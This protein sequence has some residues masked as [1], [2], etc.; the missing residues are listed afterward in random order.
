MLK[1]QNKDY[2]YNCLEVA[3]TGERLVTKIFEEKGYTVKDVSDNKEWQE[4]DID[5]LVYKDNKLIHKIEVKTEERAL[6][7]K[8]VFIETKSN[9]K[10]GWIWKTEADYIYTVIPNKKIYVI[11]K[12]EFVAWFKQNMHNCKSRSSKTTDKNGELLYNNWGRLV[13]LSILDNLEFIYSIP[14]N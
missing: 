2:F 6:Q 11:Y 13:P 7:T 10:K 1:Q 12:D 5:L 14:L 4:P 3:K 8:N 9:G